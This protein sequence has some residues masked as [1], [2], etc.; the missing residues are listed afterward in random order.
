M[1]SKENA[2]SLKVGDCVTLPNTTYPPGR[3]V[4]ARG[5]LGPG[6]ALIFRVR[7]RDKPKS[8]YIEV[9][10]DQ[11]HLLGAPHCDSKNGE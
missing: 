5:P 4:E 7:I 2:P 6:G 9:R 8:I 1:T 3:I 10:D 11:L